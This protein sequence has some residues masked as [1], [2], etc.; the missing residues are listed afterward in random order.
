MSWA[1]CYQNIL[2]YLFKISVP[3]GYG[4]AVFVGYNDDKSLAAVATAAHTLADADERNLRISLRHHLSGEEV[5]LEESDRVIF[6]D[7]HRD[8]AVVLFP[9]EYF[10]LPS[11]ALPVMPAGDSQ[12]VGS[13]VGWVGYPG[14]ARTIPCFFSGRISAFMSGIHSY[15]LDGIVINGVSGGPVFEMR[16]DDKPRLLGVVCA[17]LSHVGEL[18]TP[19]GLSLVAD[20]SH[21]HET[22]KKIRNVDEL[23]RARKA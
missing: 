19:T 6:I 9:A 14:I 10:D 13:E 11:E 20:V 21:F 3:D 4:S 15:L 1:T 12:P 17:Y 2:P 7:S 5:D 16:S 22:I 18:S 8:A 23:T